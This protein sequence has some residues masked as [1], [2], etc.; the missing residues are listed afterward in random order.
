MASVQEKSTKI[1]DSKQA[2]QYHY[3]K[4]KWCSAFI[5]PL[6]NPIQEVTNHRPETKSLSLIAGVTMAGISIVYL[7]SLMTMDS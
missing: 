5:S 1:M 2:K 4:G 3:P 6:V 7:Q